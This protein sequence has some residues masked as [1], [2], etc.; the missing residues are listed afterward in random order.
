MRSSLDVPRKSVLLTRRSKTAAVLGA[1]ALVLGMGVSELPAAAAPTGAISNPDTS[2]Q[3]AID[4]TANENHNQQVRGTVYVD[5][6]GSLITG[7]SDL[8]DELLAG[9][10]VYL[11]YM[12]GK[13]Q[14]S[15]VFYAVT[16]TDGTYRFDLRDETTAKYDA[17]K[18]VLAGD[19]DFKI[20]TWIK[21]PDSAKYSVA[22]AG[23]G[24]KASA[25]HGRLQRTVEAWDFTVGVNNIVGQKIAL[26]ERPN[27]EGWLAKPQDEWTRSGTEDGQFLNSGGYGAIKSSSVWWEVGE[28]AG[29]MPYVYGQN[30]RRGDR[31]AVGVEVVASYVNDEVANRFDAW[32]KENNGYTRVQFQAAQKQI[33]AEYEAE[34]GESAIA[35]TVVAPVKADG[36][37]YIPFKGIYGVSRTR[38]NQLAQIANL[39]TDEEWHTVAPDYSNTYG[40]YTGGAINSEKRRHINDD[41]M[42]VYP[43]VDSGYDVWM[44]SFQDNMFQPPVDFEAPSTIG[45]NLA[46]SNISAQ[47]FVFLLSNP[48]FDVLE[49]DSYNNLATPGTTVQ[50][51]TKGL[52]PNT[53]YAIQWYKTDS[54]GTNVKVGDPV[55]QTSSSS[56]ALESAPITVP[57]DLAE[58]TTY[59]AIVLPVNP[60][61]EE[62]IENNPLYADSFDADVDSDGDGVTDGQDPDKGNEGGTDEGYENESGKQYLTHGVKLVDEKGNAI[63]APSV[64]AEGKWVI[65]DDKPTDEELTVSYKNAENSQIQ[66]LGVT[67]ADKDGNTADAAAGQTEEKSAWVGAEGTPAVRNFGLAQFGSGTYTVTVTDDIKYWA[68]TKDSQLQNNGELTLDGK[69]AN[70]FV[71]L[72]YDSDDNG[73]AD[74][75]EPEQTERFQPSYADSSFEEGQGGTVTAPTFTDATG[76]TVET[77]KVPVKTIAAGGD[78]PAGFTVNADGTIT[79]ASSVAA[80]DYE[81]PVTI[82]YADG[83]TD[84]VSAKVS[85]TERTTEPSD[86]DENDPSYEG[87]SGK[88]GETVT[89]EQ[90]GDTDL[91][92]GS[93]FSSSNPDV[94]VDPS[95]GEVTV[96]VPE[97]AKPGDTITS[98]ITVTYPDGSKDTTTVTVT[99]TDPDAQPTVDP[100]PVYADTVVPA[101]KTTTVTPTNEGDAYPSGTVFAID[102]SFQAPEG[103]TI[104]IDPATGTLSVTVAPAGKDGADAESVTVP[105]VVTYPD[106]SN[107]TND[108]VNAVIKLDTDGDGQPDVTDPDDDNDGVSDED[109]AKNGTDPKNPDT[110]GDGVNDGDEAKDGTDP[111]NPDTDGDGLNDGDEKTHGTDPTNPDTDGD[112][113]NDGDEVTGD[114]NKDWD[115]DGK[116][117]PTDPTKADSDG[118]G[119]NDG[120]EIARGTDPNKADTDGDGISDGNEVSG[121]DNP[122]QDGKHDPNGEPGNTDPLNPDTDGDGISD[123]DEVTGKGNTYD[124]KPTDPNKADTDGDGLSD[125]DEVGRTDGEGKPSPTNPNDPDTDGDGVNDGDEV[126]NGTDPLVPN[127]DGK[128]STQPTD[129]GSQK[130]SGKKASVKKSLAKTGAAAGLTAVVAAGLAGLGGVLVRRRRTD[131][132]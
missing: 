126:K 23:D 120:D 108:S 63:N 68:V 96:K 49:Y 95:T 9:V 58:R 71:T 16:A 32:K 27:V 14:V 60:S 15:P 102:L 129:Q 29:S 111:L 57:E 125:G 73:V 84:T 113:V 56:G 40:A 26:Q 21:N 127:A 25:F 41:Y 13:G 52:A 118:D 130:S 82:T 17:P 6:D 12:N 37:Y 106:G 80:G 81:V 91:P 66:T 76:A 64:N 115:G 114:K 69:T 24:Y 79:V 44:G 8:G 88:P 93:S 39:V 5:R 103:Y 99:V 53:K 94:V 74:V 36:S 124:G 11:Q 117:D 1:L 47:D 50:T 107:A 131:E 19:A 38:Q 116:G 105:V 89:V 85:V 67:L 132:D 4:V 33:I 77:S 100:K 97:G 35:E 65:S 61:S 122:F 30:P 121:K 92:E 45:T 72:G 98:K 48:F 3:D 42:Y 59:T 90:T 55:I 104:T 128:P 43:I 112:G 20:R 83:T 109:E 28:A 10:V 34:T 110:D 62:V 123:G 87:A 54:T 75:D 86:A 78:V 119:L 31:P 46:G 101:G 22:L 18:F 51:E 7:N 2:A 70:Q